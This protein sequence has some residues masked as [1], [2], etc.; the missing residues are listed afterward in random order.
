MD[1]AVKCALCNCSPNQKLLPKEENAKD[2]QPKSKSNISQF[3]FF[4][5]EWRS[6]P[7]K[8]ATHAHPYTFTAEQLIYKFFNFIYFSAGLLFHRAMLLSGS[9]LSPWS[10][11]SEPAKYAAIV[12]HH[13]N[14]SPDLP[15]SHLLKCLR[16]RPLDALLSTPIRQPEFGNAFG[17]SVDGVV[18][19]KCLSFVDTPK[20]SCRRE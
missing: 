12:S 6:N 17:P 3:V 20:S 7:L 15:H 11:V 10:L 16:E 2:Q 5:T 19:G 9:G 8:S 18:I 13:V 4:S 1:A 14:C